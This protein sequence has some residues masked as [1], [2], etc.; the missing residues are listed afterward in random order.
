M[1]TES[2]NTTVNEI[3]DRMNPITLDEMKDIRLMNRIDTKYMA[4]VMLL[5]Q[6]LLSVENDFRIQSVEGLRIGNY[7]TQYYDTDNLE[8]YLLHHNSK[9]PRQKIR[10]RAYLDSGISFL[11][12]KR[13]N[14]KGRTDKIR[15][16]LPFDSVEN[17]KL[18]QRVHGFLSKFTSYSESDLIPV[19]SSTFKRIT[20]VNNNKSER[21]TIDTDL[22]FHNYR[23]GNS[24]T[25]D[26]IIV[27]ELKQEGKGHSKLKDFLFECRIPPA[28]ISKYCFGTIFTDE[29]VKYN[30]F[31]SKL[32]YI[33]KLTK[34]P[35]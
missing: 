20:L 6:L 13:K 4:P 10:A 15:V 9:R 3:C 26:N 17:L 31:K 32:R 12:V 16:Q 22:H 33:N 29:T 2:I 11:E 14:N 27:I 5:P 28:G 30:Q 23:N 19:L 25:L 8:M 18:D 24:T 7:S 21:I 34:L 1:L 35:S